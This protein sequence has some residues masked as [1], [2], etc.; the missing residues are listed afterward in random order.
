MP[1][2]HVLGSTMFYR[3]TGTGVPLIF[4][5]GNPTSSYLWRRVLPAVGDPGR[6]LAPDLI[7]MGESGQPDIAYTFD[8]SASARRNTTSARLADAGI[9]TSAGMPNS[10]I[11]PPWP[12]ALARI[13]LT[14]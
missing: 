1:V 7:G 4:L 8:D 6:R 2:A 13:P 10:R 12:T 3:E 9:S 5:H 14:V 11:H